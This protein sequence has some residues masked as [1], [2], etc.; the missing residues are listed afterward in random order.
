MPETPRNRP[1]AANQRKDPPAPTRDPVD[2]LR[3]QH[4]LHHRSSRTEEAYVGWVR[5][6]LRFR[7]RAGL[8]PDPARLLVGEISRFLSHL[9]HE[10][11]MSASTNKQ[12]LC[13]LLFI[14]R[15][16]LQQEPG[17]LDLV[18][19]RRKRKLPVVLT[20]DEVR[21]LL[22]QVRG[23]PKL[24]IALVYGTGMHLTE[25]LRLRV[26]DLDFEQGQVIVRDGK[27]EKDRITLLPTALVPMLRKQL[28]PMKHVHEKAQAK[29]WAGVELPYTLGKKYPRATYEL[30]WE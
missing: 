23:R 14:H 29:G 16:V 22:A 12:A 13:A 18:R 19:P 28:E 30:A 25:G 9:A 5:R 1:G 17:D 26:K 3:R 7:R 2:Q 4:R 21:K 10:C 20:R 8:A 24:V 27:G 6:Y 11:R 15:K